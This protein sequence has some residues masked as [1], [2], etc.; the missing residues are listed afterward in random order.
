M[1]EQVAAKTVTVC[2]NRLLLAHSANF[3][4]LTFITVKIFSVRLFYA[5]LVCC[6][7]GICRPPPLP[8]P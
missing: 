6:A 8:P 5:P 2:C 4:K 7:R 1:P 3:I